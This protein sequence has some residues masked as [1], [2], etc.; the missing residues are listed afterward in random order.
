MNNNEKLNMAYGLCEQIIEASGHTS[1]GYNVSYADDELQTV[2]LYCKDF[3]GYA[4]VAIS[5]VDYDVYVVYMSLMKNEE[6]NET[7]IHGEVEILDINDEEDLETLKKLANDEFIICNAEKIIISELTTTALSAIFDYIDIDSVHMRM[8]G[9][10]STLACC[11]M[12]DIVLV[13]YKKNDEDVHVY[14]WFIYD[15]EKEYKVAIHCYDDTDD[16]LSNVNRIVTLDDE[17]E[18]LDMFHADKWLE[19]KYN[20]YKQFE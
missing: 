3:E 15:D 7:L 4:H 1:S 18:T 10:W 12:L 16:V 13:G 14:A 2:D 6:D 5:K 11:Y 20:E 9:S 8:T 19:Q 17:S